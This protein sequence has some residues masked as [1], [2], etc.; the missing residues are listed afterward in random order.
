MNKIQSK[1]AELYPTW[2][3]FIEKQGPEK[4][5]SIHKDFTSIDQV[6]ERRR[7][8]LDDLNVVYSIKNCIPAVEYM[9]KWIEFL[10]RFSNINKP[11]TDITPVAYMLA[12]KYT[13]FTLPDLKIVFERILEGV[14]GKFY[15]SVDAQLILASFA[16]Y[17]MRRKELLQ[18]IA[19]EIG[20]QHAEIMNDRLNEVKNEIFMQLKADNP[21]MDFEDLLRKTAIAA[22][23]R[24]KEEIVNANSEE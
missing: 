8:Q 7:L 16:A 20:R 13:H 3:E 22:R 4:M 1:I 12:I 9:V 18:K 24:I 17:D 23:A 6:I 14:Y 19:N 21:N 15:G 11:L 10:N 2:K 5:L